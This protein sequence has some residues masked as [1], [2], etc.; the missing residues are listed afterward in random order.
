MGYNLRVELQK[1][2]K[3][4]FKKDSWTVKTHFSCKTSDLYLSGNLNVVYYF[5][6]RSAA[7]VDAGLRTEVI[8]GQIHSHM[9][10]QTKQLDDVKEAKDAGKG[11][12]AQTIN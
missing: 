1:C 5:Y 3:A 4:L 12:P 7:L 11:R 9:S 8:L 6:P 2:L 10:D